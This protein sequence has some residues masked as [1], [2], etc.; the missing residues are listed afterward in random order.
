MCR[1]WGFVRR[2]LDYGWGVG[3]S[4]RADHSLDLQHRDLIQ[5]SGSKDWERR[6][7]KTSRTCCESD[8]TSKTCCESGQDRRICCELSKSG[9]GREALPWARTRAA[10]GTPL[11]WVG[12]TRMIL[13]TACIYIWRRGVEELRSSAGFIIFF[14]F[15]RKVRNDG[16][17]INSK[18]M[19]SKVGIVEKVRR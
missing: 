7:D 19:E 3:G 5:E 17:T 15:M 13:A 11:L 12:P 14:I 2:K 10:G 8:K 1:A 6:Q 16:L 18:W 4:L 9:E